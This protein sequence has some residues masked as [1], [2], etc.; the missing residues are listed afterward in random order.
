MA[1]LTLPPQS[2]A[3]EVYAW[4]KLRHPNIL[5]FLGYVFCPDLG[6]PLIISEWMDHGNA[7]SFVKSQP[8][9]DLFIVTKVVCSPD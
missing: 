6:C 1:R 5:P 3:R 7:L 8:R 2:F 9:L 4:S